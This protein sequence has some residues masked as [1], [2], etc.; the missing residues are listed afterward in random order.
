[1]DGKGRDNSQIFKENIGEFGNLEIWKFGNKKP[2]I[3][4]GYYP[5]ACKNFPGNRPVVFQFQLTPK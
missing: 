4:T 2:V 3:K 1:L 5:L